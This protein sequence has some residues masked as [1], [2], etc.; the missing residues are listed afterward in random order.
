[1]LFPAK[2]LGAVLL[3]ACILGLAPRAFAG[4]A[5]LVLQQEQKEEPK[6]EAKKPD[7]DI[8]KAEREKMMLRDL[9]AWKKLQVK[10]LDEVIDVKKT[11]KAVAYPETV[12][13]ADKAKLTELFTK[14]KEAGGGVRTTRNLREM[15]KLGHSA[16]LFLIN[17]LR[18][19]D[20]KNADEMMFAWEINQTLRDLTLG[21][22][23]GYVPINPGEEVDPRKS[24]WN[25]MTVKAW[26]DSAEKWWPTKEK[27]EEALKKKKA[28]REAEDAEGAKETEKA[29]KKKA[30]KS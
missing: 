5:V 8:L 24:Q 2:P 4:S 20:Y 29:E 15:K 16:L 18:E 12:T 30:P 28:Q 11:T 9:E 7:D 10:S 23:A 6:K 17:Q 14:A 19:I 25:A 1:M 26:L 27:Y 21:A 13:D 3:S 22:N